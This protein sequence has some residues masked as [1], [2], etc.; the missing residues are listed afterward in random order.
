MMA[1]DAVLMDI[2]MNHVKT[3]FYVWLCLALLGL[4]ACGDGKPASR[5]GKSDAPPGVSFYYWKTVYDPGPEALQ[6]L[7][8]LQVARLYL[9]FFEV[10]LNEWGEPVPHA[11]TRFVQKP[12]L[13]VAPVIYFDLKT[14]GRPD[15]DT[16][17]LA[18]S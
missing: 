12:H 13:P 2:A 4:C 9:R 7:A 16:D 14:F 5:G 10:T 3:V 8:E 11:T 18:G 15:L 17:K 1:A 6:R